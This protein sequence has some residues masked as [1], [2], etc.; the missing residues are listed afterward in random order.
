VFQLQGGLLAT[1]V[2]LFL[3]ITKT[4][5]PQG[6]ALQGGTQGA[7]DMLYCRSLYRRV[8]RWTGSVPYTAPV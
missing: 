2:L 3:S 5:A 8:D 6:D 7:A 4:I 1:P